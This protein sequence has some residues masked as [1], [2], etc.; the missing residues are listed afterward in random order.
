MKTCSFCLCFLLLLTSLWFLLCRLTAEEV[1]SI[2]TDTAN[3]WQGVCIS[4]ASPT[5]SESAATVKSLIKS[6]DLG[7]S[8]MQYTVVFFFFLFEWYVFF[9]ILCCCLVEIF[10]QC[11]VQKYCLWNVTMPLVP[12]SAEKK[13][14]GFETQ[15]FPCFFFKGSTGQN[16]TVQKVPR[17]PLSGIPVRTAPAAAVSPMQVRGTLSVTRVFEWIDAVFEWHGFSV[18]TYVRG[19]GERETHL[20]ICCETSNALVLTKRIKV[21]LPLTSV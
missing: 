14:A 2:E 8:G 3:R 13:M 21:S 10:C 16:I 1:E 19:Q 20:F 17:S 7:C 12:C 5:P 4:R 15:S 18:P 9:V 11:L 6:F